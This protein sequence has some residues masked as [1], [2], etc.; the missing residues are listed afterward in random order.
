MET[1]NTKIEGSIGGQVRTPINWCAPGSTKCFVFVKDHIYIAPPPE[2]SKDNPPC[3]YMPP[4]PFVFKAGDRVEGVV[5][6][7][8]GILTA[9]NGMKLPFNVLQPAAPTP[10]YISQPQ[11][12]YIQK[13]EGGTGIGIT[14]PGVD[15]KQKTD[16]AKDP[17]TGGTDWSSV[18]SPN[19]FWRLVIVVFFIFLFLKYMLPIIKKSFAKG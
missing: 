10:T 15:D 18:F 13:P 5:D 14:H 6:T 2:C 17:W 4:P 8:T 12:V 1:G 7:G 11:I 9:D 19:N 16:A 3:P